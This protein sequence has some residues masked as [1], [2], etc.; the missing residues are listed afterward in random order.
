LLD[1]AAADTGVEREV[2]TRAVRLCGTGVGP[3]ASLRES[4][5][6]SG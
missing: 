2:L 1:A 6:S 4:L 5:R 3:S